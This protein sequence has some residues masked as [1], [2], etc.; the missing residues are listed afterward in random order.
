M[1]AVQGE[2]AQRKA[3]YCCRN[4]FNL[5]SRLLCCP[6]EWRQ[7]KR[8]STLLLKFCKLKQ[9]ADRADY[10]RTVWCVSADFRF[11]ITQDTNHEW[12]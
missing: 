12:W 6:G 1:N 8:R 7:R 2:G 3:R 5:G 4:P 9:L 10:S 11:I